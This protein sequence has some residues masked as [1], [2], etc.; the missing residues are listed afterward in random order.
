MDHGELRYSLRSLERFAPW[1]RQIFLVTDA[2]C[3][4]WLKPDHP[5]LRLVDH[6]EIFP[7]PGHLPTFSS[8]AIECHLHRINGLSE[9]FLYFNDDCFLGKTLSATDFYQDGKALIPLTKRRNNQIFR[10]MLRYAR[11]CLSGNISD[12]SQ[13]LDSTLW[14]TYQEIAAIPER[15]SVCSSHFYSTK[16][17]LK[18][19]ESLFG[20]RLFFVPGH[21][22][23]VLRRSAL[24]ALEEMIPQ[25]LEQTS[26]S[27]FRSKNG[28]NFVDL[29]Q[30]YLLETGQGRVSSLQ[31]GYLSNA[32][33][34]P[35]W[36]FTLQ[37][38]R[39]R[40]QQLHLFCFNDL[41]A[42]PQP[43]R[44]HKFKEAL[45]CLLPTPSSFET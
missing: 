33:C 5:R 35:A 34:V 9:F 23:K 3:P 25:Q 21:F 31:T 1:V 32:S 16:N 6:R 8:N 38:W 39:I 12:E 28:I 29:C 18:L 26:A 13:K 36:N 17:T 41:E 24:F 42:H 22:V 15:P 37:M 2:Q 4:T 30:C 7:N 14:Y 44:I 19:L 40:T 20:P 11:D 27:K 45:A 43:W 10:K